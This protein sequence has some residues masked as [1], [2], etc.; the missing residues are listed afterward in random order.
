MWVLA[1]VPLVLFANLVCLKCARRRMRAV[2]ST[3]GPA[4]L[5]EKFPK[6]GNS[7]AIKLLQDEG[8]GSTSY[9]M[10]V[11]SDTDPPISPVED[12]PEP[13]AQTFSFPSVGGH[14]EIPEEVRVAKPEIVDPYKPQWA[15]SCVGDSNLLPEDADEDPEE[16]AEEEECSPWL[17]QSSPGR[18]IG[19]EEVTFGGVKG[20]GVSGD[21]L[22]PLS[23]VLRQ[24]EW[25]IGEQERGGTRDMDG[26]SLAVLTDRQTK[27]PNGLLSSLKGDMLESL[28][29][30]PYS[31]QGCWLKVAQ[32]T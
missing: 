28:Q 6:V 21:L 3:V 27:M 7:N 10:S 5:F 12:I 20:L 4:W 17:S 18:D 11:C 32:N 26:L 31:P 14:T 9:W 22:C 16:D 30:N 23:L 1:A 15:D 29:A 19:L 2:C 24:T 13:V 8:H 25:S